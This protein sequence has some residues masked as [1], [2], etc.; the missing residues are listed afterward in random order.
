MMIIHSRSSA[1]MINNRHDQH[2]RSVEAGFLGGSAA[3]MTVRVRILSHGG[4]RIS[5]SR[6]A[7]RDLDQHPLKMIKDRRSPFMINTKRRRR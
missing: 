1:T 7:L 2:R 6:W 3:A 4:I 5:R